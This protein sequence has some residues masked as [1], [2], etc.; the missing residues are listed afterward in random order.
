MQAVKARP[1]VHAFICSSTG[2]PTPP[3]LEVGQVFLGVRPLALQLRQAAAHHVERV[4]QGAGLRGEEQW[5][6]QHVAAC[7]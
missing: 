3:H 7:G 1:Q 5:G 4:G 2:A 6:R